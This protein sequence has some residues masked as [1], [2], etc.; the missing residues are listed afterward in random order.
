MA[1]RV[2]HIGQQRCHNHG[3]REA[4]GR[5]VACRRMYC[6]ECVSEYDGR[7]LC[8]Q[9]LAGQREHADVPRRRGLPLLPFQLAAGLLV[10]T[11]VFY[12]AGSLMTVAPSAFFD[13][14]DQ[15]NFLEV[16]DQRP[17]DAED[18]P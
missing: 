16:E 14:E 1:S 13:T 15:W 3:E 6:R 5:C 2:Q 12:G 7:L 11:G 10:L 4:A 9:C 18:G 17:A 8:A